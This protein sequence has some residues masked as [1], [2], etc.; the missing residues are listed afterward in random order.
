MTQSFLDGNAKIR[1]SAMQMPFKRSRESLSK[2]FSKILL[3]D[4]HRCT[5]N[6]RKISQLRLKS[7][8]VYRYARRLIAL[9]LNY[10]GLSRGS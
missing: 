3:W 7:P 9:T 2:R 10:T 1:Y 6:S 4:E 8:S 5:V